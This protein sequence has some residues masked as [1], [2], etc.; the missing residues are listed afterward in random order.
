MYPQPTISVPRESDFEG[1]CFSFA[2][3]DVYND[4]PK[5]GDGA[6]GSRRVPNGLREVLMLGSRRPFA[7]ACST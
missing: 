1:I 5:F 6:A 2:Q 7:S 4:L 3:R